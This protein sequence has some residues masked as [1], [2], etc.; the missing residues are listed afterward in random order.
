MRNFMRICV[1]SCVF[2]T[3]LG[4]WL[5]PCRKMPKKRNTPFEIHRAAAFDLRICE[6]ATGGSS[7]VITVKCRSCDVFGKEEPAQ[8][9]RERVR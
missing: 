2:V 5:S 4:V 1:L 7:A 8:A 9:G 6:L 3:S